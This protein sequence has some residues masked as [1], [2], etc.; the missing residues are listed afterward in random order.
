MRIFHDW[1]IEYTHSQYISVGGHYG[2][3]RDQEHLLTYTFSARSTDSFANQTEPHD[4]ADSGNAFTWGPF[5]P[6]PPQNLED[7]AE[8]S[9][10]EPGGPLLHFDSVLQH[11]SPDGTLSEPSAQSEVSYRMELPSPDM[12]EFGFEDGGM[13]MQ[14]GEMA[15]RLAHAG[16]GLRPGGDGMVPEGGGFIVQGEF[17]EPYMNGTIGTQWNSRLVS[18]EW[19]G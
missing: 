18:L 19:R 8:L 15:T 2:A 13:G 10:T 9:G 17:G 11:S 6:S 16:A 7:V 12:Y 4:A 5:Q 14:M 3:P 1:S